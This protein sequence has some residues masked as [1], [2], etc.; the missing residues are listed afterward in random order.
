MKLALG[1]GLGKILY[2]L[3]FLLEW[4]DAF[5]VHLETQKLQMSNSKHT[6]GTD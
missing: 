4:A 6:L 2:S 5:A 1:G 3:Y